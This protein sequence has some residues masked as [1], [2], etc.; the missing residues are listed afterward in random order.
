MVSS[1]RSCSRDDRRAGVWPACLP[2]AESPCVAGAGGAAVKAPST[3]QAPARPC[4]SGPVS[5]AP[6][7]LRRRQ[8]LPA[9]LPSPGH[10]PDLCS[11]R[12]AGRRDDRPMRETD[13][14]ADEVLAEL[15]A[16][17][18]PSIKKV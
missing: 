15:A 18:S 14:T 11:Q 8:A 5:G 10:T 7:G 1:S 16:L 4:E 3:G 2:L 17:G 9:G 13:M 6:P 12:Q